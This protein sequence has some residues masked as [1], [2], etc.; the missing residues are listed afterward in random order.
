MEQLQILILSHTD[1][2]LKNIILLLSYR[3][4]YQWFIKGYDLNKQ[5]H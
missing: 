4:E 2:Q 5:P 1:D 3:Y